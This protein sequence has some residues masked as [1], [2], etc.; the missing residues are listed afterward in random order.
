[1]VSLFAVF[2]FILHPVQVLRDRLSDDL[3]RGGA[4]AFRGRQQPG[5][6]RFIGA[7]GAEVHGF[8]LMM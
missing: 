2:G 1:V 6:K 3:A 8:N 4:E 7:V 5:V